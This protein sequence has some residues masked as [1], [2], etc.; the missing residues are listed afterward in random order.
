MDDGELFG[1]LWAV[2]MEYEEGKQAKEDDSEEVVMVLT[3]S[4]SMVHA[5]EGTW[6][7]GGQRRERRGHAP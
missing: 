4:W 5:V 7:M 3:D 2:S 6:R 1:I